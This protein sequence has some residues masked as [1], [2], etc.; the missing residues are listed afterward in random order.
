[1]VQSITISSGPVLQMAVDTGGLDIPAPARHAAVQGSIV[2]F[3]NRSQSSAQGPAR[4]GDAAAA[5]VGRMNEANVAH[6]LTYRVLIEAVGEVMRREC[7]T[8]NMQA[9]A[10]KTMR[11][12]L[13]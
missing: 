7:H 9:G 1:M 3:S 8:L 5:A 11:G 4:S 10:G 12:L 6:N 2:D 13:P